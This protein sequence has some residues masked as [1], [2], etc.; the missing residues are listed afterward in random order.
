MSRY[1]RVS[2]ECKKPGGLLIALSDKDKSLI[3]NAFFK[4]L[5][6]GR[7]RFGGCDNELTNISRYFLPN[8]FLGT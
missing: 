8:I 2:E 7:P 1:R 3:G 5:V 4:N 6:F